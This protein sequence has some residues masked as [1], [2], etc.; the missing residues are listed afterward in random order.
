MAFTFSSDCTFA[1]I[2][3]TPSFANTGVNSP[4]FIFSF[5]RYVL[6]VPNAGPGAAVRVTL[7]NSVTDAGGGVAVFEGRKRRRLRFA[8]PAA[9]GDEAV[10]V[11]HHVA[12]GIRPA[13]L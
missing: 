6:F 11:S 13:F 10:D 9:A 7:Q 3:L 2:S 8:G 1:S 5:S 4:S 12:E